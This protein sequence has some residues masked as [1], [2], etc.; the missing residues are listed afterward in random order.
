[1]VTLIFYSDEALVVLIIGADR[2]IQAHHLFCYRLKL[3]T[4][5]FYFEKLRFFGNI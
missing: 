4:I 3:C 5:N 1:M 2:F